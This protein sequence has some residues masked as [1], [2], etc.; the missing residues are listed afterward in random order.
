MRKLIMLIALSAG[1]VVGGAASADAQARPFTIGISGGPSFPLG[2][3][4]S[5]EFG[6][7]YH[8]Q[9][10]V[11]FTPAMLPFGARVDLLWQ[12]FPDEHEG[13]E[14]EIGGLANAILALPLGIARPYALGGIGAIHHRSPEEDHGDHGH[15]GESGARFGWALG[16]GIEFP[17]AGL[18]GVLEA[19]Y[20]GL[21]EG[22]A[23]LPIG[24]GIRF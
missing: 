1:A 4:F 8:V 24:V 14:R 5:E 16:G 20:L 23:A 6:T 11:G 13:R 9:G 2:S 10:S 19:R 21:G 17:F 12:E 18:T 22:H 3:E 15:E 7:G